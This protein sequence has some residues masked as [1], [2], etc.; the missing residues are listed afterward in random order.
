M[1][2]VMWGLMVRNELRFLIS[3]VDEEVGNNVG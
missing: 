2:D 1:F 3:G